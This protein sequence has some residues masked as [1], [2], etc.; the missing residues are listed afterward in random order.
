[1]ITADPFT[2]WVYPGCGED[3]CAYLIDADERESCGDP[4]ALG[5]SYCAT[6]Y[7]ITHITRGS[8]A[9][10]QQLREFETLAWIV[11]GGR[12]VRL[13]LTRSKH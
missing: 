11:G 12:F 10:T 5:S 3:C 2:A 7:A 9:E 13:I 1:M 8:K 4:C 6:H